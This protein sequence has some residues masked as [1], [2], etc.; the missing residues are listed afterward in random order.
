M[1]NF[2]RHNIDNIKGKKA[3]S[4]ERENPKQSQ[5]QRSKAPRNISMADRVS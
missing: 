2:I 1:R 3:V 4:I 5:V